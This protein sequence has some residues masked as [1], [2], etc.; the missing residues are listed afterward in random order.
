[1][2]LSLDEQWIP[3]A[4]ARYRC[5][6]PAD[7]TGFVAAMAQLYRAAGWAWHGR[8]VWV[9]SPTVAHTATMLAALMVRRRYQGAKEHLRATEL[10]GLLNGA[11]CLLGNIS[12]MGQHMPGR[13]PGLNWLLG[14][15][16]DA[17][18]QWIE[19]NLGPLEK[20]V[21]DARLTGL[22]WK[23]DSREGGTLGRVVREMLGDNA[24]Y[25]AVDQ[26][27][28]GACARSLNSVLCSGDMPWAVAHLLSAGGHAYES[29][30][31]HSLLLCFL[32]IYP[33][34]CEQMLD[35]RTLACARAFEAASAS[36]GWW[37]PHRDFVVVCERPLA[38][39]LGGYAGLAGQPWAS[40]TG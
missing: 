12:P 10:D 18:E 13:L 6:E 36:V 31:K 37:W 28:Q 22:R 9:A 27:V 23:G 17:I 30:Y 32:H 33:E 4:L 16:G 29:P 39:G 24:V 40:T 25:A 11:T 20:A 35:A 38:Q 7:R 26:T 2:N 3:M 21:D 19:E 14:H 5:A 34:L 1:M 15:T 8:V